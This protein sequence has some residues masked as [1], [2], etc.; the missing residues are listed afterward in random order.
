MGDALSPFA[1]FLVALQFLTRLPVWRVMPKVEDHAGALRQAMAF[2][3]V[4]GALIGCVTGGVFWLCLMVWPAWVAVLLALAVEVLLTGALH[5]DGVADFC[6]AFGGG[7]AREDIERILKDSGIGSYGTV[8]LLLG[9]GL[10]AAAMVALPH[11]FVF[12]AIVAAAALGRWL[13]LPITLVLPPVPGRDGL[14]KGLDH[15]RGLSDLVLGSCL[16][17]P[18]LMPVF[19]YAPGPSAVGVA[20]ALVFAFWLTRYVRRRLGG[21][22]GDVLGFACFGGQLLFLLGAAVRF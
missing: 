22:T 19:L 9:V 14:A 2:L 6:D 8:G 5:E 11:A 15:R 21:V 12:W 1:R 7:W 4:A 17:V 18:F 13:V 20:L 16:T 10:R 3:P